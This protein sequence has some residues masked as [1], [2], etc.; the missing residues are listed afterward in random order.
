MAKKIL[1][2]E[3]E[4]HIRMS[5]EARLKANGYQIVTAGDGLEGYEI[6]QKERPD[7]ILM[8]VMMPKLDGYQALEKLKADEATK[9]IPVVMLTAR[10]QP[11]DVE[12]AGMGG[13]VDYIVKPFTPV[14][15]LEKIK[16][17]LK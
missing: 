16:N 3:D 7:L 14:I 9:A 10:A 13:A 6:A 15:L 8:D 2:V 1:V 4:P 17:A 11:E 5:M 12:K